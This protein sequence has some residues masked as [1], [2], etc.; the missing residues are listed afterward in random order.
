MTR[1]RVALVLVM[2]AT[3]LPISG[4]K[5]RTSP[6][7]LAVEQQQLSEEE[8][9]FARV[10]LAHFDLSKSGEIIVGIKN[11]PVSKQLVQYLNGSSSKLRFA[12]R[13]DGVVVAW[14]FHLSQIDYFHPGYVY[15]HIDYR[16]SL[17]GRGDSFG[18]V[19][20]RDGADWQLIDVFQM[21][22]YESLDRKAYI[23]GKIAPKNQ[24]GLKGD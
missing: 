20:R 14:I 24:A 23:R 9:L 16:S 22:E 17:N 1:T 8:R 21:G 19:L 12:N 7:I 11:G 3:F 6:E 10:A 15:L 18:H 13:K 5:S 4:C 2:T